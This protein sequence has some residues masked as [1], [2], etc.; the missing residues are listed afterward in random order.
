[1]E[2]WACVCIEVRS[3]NKPAR[4]DFAGVR[5]TERNAKP[6]STAVSLE[7]RVKS[8]RS[9]TRK[10]NIMKSIVSVEQ[11]YKNKINRTLTRLSTCNC[12]AHALLENP[13]TLELGSKR[14]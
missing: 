11:S 3:V 13:S 7:G 12:S 5:P 14:P 4:S 1:M 8:T 10:E 6:R 2:A 9:F